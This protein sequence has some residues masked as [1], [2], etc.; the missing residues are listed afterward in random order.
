MIT[1]LQYHE[2]LKVHSCEE[3]KTWHSNGATYAGG[4]G[5]SRINYSFYGG[6]RFDPNEAT[7]TPKE[8]MVVGNNMLKANN[9]NTVPDQDGCSKKGW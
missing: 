3:P 9:V 8:Q 6:K 4:L 7:S 2:W 1:P 5:I